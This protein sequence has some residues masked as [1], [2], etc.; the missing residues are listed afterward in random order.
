MAP[1]VQAPFAAFDSSGRAIDRVIAAN[2]AALALF[3]EEL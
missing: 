3:T 2:K 1:I